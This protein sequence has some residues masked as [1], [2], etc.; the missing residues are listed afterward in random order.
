MTCL[1][2]AFLTG[3]KRVCKVHTDSMLLLFSLPAVSAA[4]VNL[5]YHVA[6]AGG[7]KWREKKTSQISALETGELKRGNGFP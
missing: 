7:G 4:S 6:F 3:S 2:L 5:L 1:L